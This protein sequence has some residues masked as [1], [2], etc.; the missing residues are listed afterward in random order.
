MSKMFAWLGVCVVLLAGT[1]AQA[2]SIGINLSSG[3]GLS[4]VG[5]SF[6]GGY[7]AQQNWNNWNMDASSFVAS[8]TDN[9]GQT[10]TTNLGVGLDL[11]WSGGW[12]YDTGVGAGDGPANSLQYS[13]WWAQYGPIVHISNIPY[14]TYDVAVLHAGFGNDWRWD[15]EL[16]KT[17]SSYTTPSYEN[18]GGRFAAVQIIGPVSAVPEPSTFVLAGLGLAG[19]SLGALRKKFRRVALS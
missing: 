7:S 13:D 11:A 5:S 4:T 1:V 8:V 3:N 17:G 9:L 16:G 19:L 10:V 2:E 14:S 12:D 15:V 6:S 18:G